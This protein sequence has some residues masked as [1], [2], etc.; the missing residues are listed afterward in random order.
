MLLA[1]DANLSPV[2]AVQAVAAVFGALSVISAGVLW[3]L[4]PRIREWVVTQ[5]KAA[6]LVQHELRPNSGES[7][8]DHAR[9]ARKS[10]ER[11]ESRLNQIELNQTILREQFQEHIAEAADG[12][13]RLA[14]VEQNV[15]AITRLLI[16][17]LGR[18]QEDIDLLT[19]SKDD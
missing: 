9:V 10:A 16:G 11:A 17:R 5:T 14:D 19:R 6:E 15:N 1:T 3:L 7:L 12:R 8:H 13:E 18:R 2:G 4:L